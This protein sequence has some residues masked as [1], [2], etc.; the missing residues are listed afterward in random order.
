MRRSLDALSVLSTDDLADYDVISD[1]PR[2]MESSIAD[3]GAPLPF[4]GAEPA[5][6]PS[7]REKFATVELTAEEIQT[8]V[9][10]SLNASLAG[11]RGDDARTW[12]VYV[13]GMFGPLMPRD[14][15]Q[16]RQ[17][18]LSFPSVHLIVGVFSDEACEQHGLDP[19]LPHE[20]RCEV[21]RHCR[22]VDE[23]IP[24]APW[25]VYDKFLRT[26]MIDFVAIDEGVSI[27]PDCDRDRL[28]G[29]DL[30]KSLRKSIATR[31][32]NVS[33]PIPRH[34]NPFQGKVEE[35]KKESS[36][37][38]GGGTLKNIPASL[39]QAQE[40]MRMTEDPTTAD[41]PPETGREV[42]EDTPFEEPRVDEFGTGQG[43]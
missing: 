35:D 12:R 9:Q 5:P 2:S 14:V 31:K 28:K 1:G 8:Y 21:L 32:T 15:L 41:T 40:A 39:R 18:K 37:P 20:D 23:V 22:W 7:A 13:D 17:A 16:L 43:I 36:P 33:T 6:L 26:R 27:D 30:V 29:Y 24:D 38:E 42:G 10:R 19:C 34:H 25:T 3:L 11:G 4:A